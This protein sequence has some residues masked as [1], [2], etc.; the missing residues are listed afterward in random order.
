MLLRVNDASDGLSGSEKSYENMHVSKY[1]SM[2]LF[3]TVIDEASSFP[4]EIQVTHTNPASKE[5]STLSIP[6][7]PRDAASLESVRVNMHSSQTCG[8][9][10]SQIF[11]DW[12]SER[13][14]FRVIFVYLEDEEKRPVLGNVPPNA[15]ERNAQLQQKMEKEKRASQ[16][17]SLSRVSNAAWSILGYNSAS[18]N[19]EAGK[20]EEGPSITFADCAPYLIASTTSLANVSARLPDDEE[21]DMTKFRPNIIVSGANEA[22]EEDFWGELSISSRD[23]RFSED[24]EQTPCEKVGLQLTANCLRCASLNVDYATGEPGTSASGQILKKLQSDRRVDAGIKYSP[25]FGRY[26]FLQQVT[27]PGED[28]ITPSVQVGDEVTVSKYNKERTVFKW[29]G[30]GGRSKEDLYPV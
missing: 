24:G 10:M 9:V 19:E 18:N 12:F 26:G 20:N 4:P 14:G 23:T 30:M 28:K 21:M 13:F 7:F 27:T 15:A 6:L 11:N 17:S 29:P 2:C 16:S 5:Q 8:R 25:V 1:T 3:T 22:F